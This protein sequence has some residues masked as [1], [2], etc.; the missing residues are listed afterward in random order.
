[1]A[2]LQCIDNRTISYESAEMSQG[3]LFS[4]IGGALVNLAKVNFIENSSLDN[5]RVIVH[6]ENQEKL[7]LDGT[8]EAVIMKIGGG[9]ERPERPAP[10]SIPGPG[11]RQG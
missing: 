6:F 3:A 4:V 7:V 8:V 1:M 10:T 5:G 9:Q 11:R 2:G